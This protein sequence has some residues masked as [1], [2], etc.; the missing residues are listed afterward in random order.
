MIYLIKYI[1]KKKDPWNQ[2][3][4]NDIYY[5]YTRN[6][7]ID[8]INN[9]TQGKNILEI[10]CGNGFSVN[11]YHSIIPNKNF[12]GCD[13]S[14]IAIEKATTKYPN[15]NFFQYDVRKKFD[16]KNKYDVII[17]SDLLWYIIND[18]KICVNNALEMLENDGK[19]IYYNDFMVDNQ[20]FG[21][22]IIDGFDGLVEFFKINFADKKILYQHQSEALDNK[23]L[24]ILI[25]NK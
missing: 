8:C 17:I 9:K 23:Y 18:L 22:D 21:K 13:V 3:N 7:I 12:T 11:Y 2:S 14:K 5:N 25:I 4:I 19:L 15:I 10:G 6:H 20:R 16:K 1:Y 24:G